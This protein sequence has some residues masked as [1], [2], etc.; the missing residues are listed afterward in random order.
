MRAGDEMTCRELVEVLTAYLEGALASEDRDR[1][2]A[3]VA[4]CSYCAEYVA[5]M[6]ETIDALGRVDEESIPPERRAELLAAFR[7][8]RDA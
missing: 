2:E 4:A 6:R 1:L 8:W 7:G 3:H 5:Q